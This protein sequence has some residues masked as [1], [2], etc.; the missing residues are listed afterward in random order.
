VS[1]F[2]LARIAIHDPVAYG[3]YL[4]GTD[5]ILARYGAE[6]L[7][8]DEEPVVLEGDWSGSRTVLIRFPDEETARAWY[9]SAAYR[10]LARSRFQAS[11]AD[12]IFLR[13]RDE[14]PAE[15]R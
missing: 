6:V 13:G 5:A 4:A 2:F 10:E 12:A 11:R 15:S 9:T 8:V 3:R 1:C 7:A 14:P